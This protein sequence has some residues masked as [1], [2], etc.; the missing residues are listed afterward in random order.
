MRGTVIGEVGDFRAEN[1]EEVLV[2]GG[3]ARLGNEG[4]GEK[5][6]E[7]GVGWSFEKGKAASS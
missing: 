1:S 2:E 6:S 5:R 7:I 3:G 4:T